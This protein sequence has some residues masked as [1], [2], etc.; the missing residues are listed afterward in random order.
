MNCLCTSY[1]KATEWAALAGARWLGRADEDAA[2][3][4]AAAAMRSA[5]D[6]LPI[7]G[8]VIIGAHAGEE[9]A[10]GGEVGAGGQG[11]DL[12]LDPLEGRG[13]VARGGTGAMAMLAVAPAD[14]LRRLPDMYMRTMAVWTPR[15]GGDRPTATGRGQHR[16]D[17][18]QLRP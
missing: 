5:L 7:S 6:Q 18:R 14:S 3:D 17:R 12:A 10:P 16:R 2:E 1:A 15:Q 9:L 13:V 4:A 11:V 8:R